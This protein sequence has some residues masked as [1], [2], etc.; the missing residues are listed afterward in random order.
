MVAKGAF[1]NTRILGA[2][3]AAAAVSFAAGASAQNTAPASI[4]V[5]MPG[6]AN[7]GCPELAAE[8]AR[9]D[10]IIGQAQQNQANAQG[11]GQVAGAVGA[12]ATSAA[13]YSGTLGSVPGLGFLAR[14]AENA[15][16]ARR[17]AGQ[18]ERKARR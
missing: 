2:V 5:S 16:R 12:A 13:L 4:Q 17:A 3:I 10:Q 15:A 8:I 11:N 9:M 1:M 7:M 14:G 18:A 6:D